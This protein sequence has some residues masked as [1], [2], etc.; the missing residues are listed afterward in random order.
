MN[1]SPR[2]LFDECLPAPA[3]KELAESHRIEFAALVPML[4]EQG[5]IDDEW[6]PRLA[7]EGRWVVIT[8]DGGRQRSRGNKLPRLCRE[9]EVTHVIIT[10]SIHSKKA[11]E[12][13]RILSE[14]WDRIVKAVAAAPP[15]TR[16][17]LRYKPAK[18]SNILRVVLE[19]ID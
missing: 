14:S 5:V 1:P 12:K 6:I 17:K 18:G 8:T 4:G 2:F 15:G 3:I 11:A 19:R 13:L 7:T 9:H 10:S 16:F